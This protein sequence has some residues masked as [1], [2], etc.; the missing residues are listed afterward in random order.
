MKAPVYCQQ[1]ATALTPRNADGRERLVCPSCGFIHYGNPTPV[2]AALVEHQGEALLVRNKG[3]PDTW[4]GLV[5]GFLE[6][7]ESPQDGVLRELKEELN[8]DGTV[9]SLIGVYP[10]EMRNEVIIAFHVRAT[11]TPQAGE[12]LADF[13]R[14]A[15]HKLRP[16]PQGTGMAV[17]DWL[18]AQNPTPQEQKP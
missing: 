2:V 5:S 11:G 3:W 15:I 4:F 17:R 16:W 18:A 14:V 10:F 13:K 7:G 8:L 9:V 1:C 6:A 12:E